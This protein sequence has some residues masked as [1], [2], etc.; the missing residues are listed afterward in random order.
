[1]KSRNVESPKPE[2]RVETRVETRFDTRDDDEHSQIL[3]SARRREHDPRNGDEFTFD[4][5]FAFF[6]RPKKGYLWKHP[7]ADRE[8]F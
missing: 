3:N 4:P 5:F 7:F 8:A 1:M 2:A 6:E